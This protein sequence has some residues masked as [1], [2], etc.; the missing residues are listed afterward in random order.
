[1]ISKVQSARTAEAIPCGLLAHK[2]GWESQDWSSN[3]DIFKSPQWLKSVSFA[4]CTL[5][6]GAQLLT[7]WGTGVVCSMFGQL[8]I[9]LKHVNNCMCKQGQLINGCLKKKIMFT[10]KLNCINKATF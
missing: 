8:I 7:E 2:R 6:W 3:P 4:L 9:I 10:E 1:M 5:R